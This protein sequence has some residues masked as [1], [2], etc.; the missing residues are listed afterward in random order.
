MPFRDPVDASYYE[1]QRK[2]I[3]RCCGTACLTDALLET[4]ARTANQLETL[5]VGHPPRTDRYGQPMWSGLCR[6]W[7]DG[8]SL[9]SNESIARIG[10]L[11]EGRSNVGFWRDHPLWL[12]LE[13]P[14][15]WD[16]ALL[17]RVREHVGDP[18]RRVVFVGGGST[19]P[20]MPV[21]VEIG[22]HDLSKL[23]S[24]KSLDA[25]SVLLMLAR[26]AETSNA[27]ARHAVLSASAFSILAKV[28]LENP[29]LGAAKDDLFEALRTSLWSCWY[30]HGIRQELPRC[31]F[32][33]HLAR[34]VEDD[35]AECRVCVGRLL[36]D[37]PRAGGRIVDQFCAIVGL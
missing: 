8:V 1:A 28:V 11:S 37:G 27:D 19:W 13:E 3:R 26:L 31:A 29:Q 24:L 7:R 5:I 10:E 9:P 30:L 35:D 33:E 4:G 21:L 36:G 15:R 14:S 6:R 12:L 2:R 34:L 32:D 20:G 17:M 22:D 25:L 23:R 18:V 16:P